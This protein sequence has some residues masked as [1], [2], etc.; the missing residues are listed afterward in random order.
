[1]AGGD[2]DPVDSDDAP[3]ERLYP[4][5][6]ANIMVKG[7]HLKVDSWLMPSSHGDLPLLPYL[8]DAK[9]LP[10]Q[11]VCGMCLVMMPSAI[12]MIAAGA[13]LSPP[14]FVLVTLLYTLSLLKVIQFTFGPGKH[15][16]LPS[17]HGGLLHARPSSYLRGGHQIQ[18][19]ITPSMDRWIASGNAANLM[20]KG[21]FDLHG[22]VVGVKLLELFGIEDVEK[23]PKPVEENILKFGDVTLSGEVVLVERGGVFAAPGDRD[24][25]YIQAIG[26]VWIRF[27]TDPSIHALVIEGTCETVVINA[28]IT[29]AGAIHYPHGPPLMSVGAWAHECSKWDNDYSMQY[30]WG[31][32]CWRIAIVGPA[33]SSS[34]AVAVGDYGRKLHCNQGLALAH[35]KNTI[36][37]TEVDSHSGPSLI[38]GKPNAGEKP[39][40]LNSKEATCHCYL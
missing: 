5:R 9:F 37:L 38:G 23:V 10:Y 29:G 16:S 39:I 6:R 12:V 31:D 8:N 17:D 3:P 25:L 35:V 27:V 19:L 40:D 36:P 18:S 22:V 20:T 7:I 28:V 4:L 30:S 15:A 32:G 21:D 1:L 11:V 24:G 14:M 26:G 34:C 33:E 13:W 2:T